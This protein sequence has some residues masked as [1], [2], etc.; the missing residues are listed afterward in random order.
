MALLRFLDVT[1]RAGQLRV[2]AVI[3]EIDPQ[4]S[5]DSGWTRSVLDVVGPVPAQDL[6]AALRLAGI[7]V[8]TLIQ[9]PRSVEL[10][11]ILNVAV[12]TVGFTVFGGIAGMILGGIMGYVF[13][14]LDP[15]CFTVL[16]GGP[17]AAAIIQFATGGGIIAASAGA[18]V[19]MTVGILR[20]AHLRRTG[21]DVPFLRF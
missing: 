4:A 9:R 5:I 7:R 11:D 8:E 3:R 21:E 10:F 17:C 18:L 20:L 12:L 14:S 6:C 19:T 16:E 15:A 2:E 1:D 13:K